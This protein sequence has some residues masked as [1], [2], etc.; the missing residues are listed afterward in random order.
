MTKSVP[1]GN[2][3][4]GNMASLHCRSVARIEN[5]TLTAI[6]DIDTDRLS[7]MKSRYQVAA[8]S[9]S[10]TLIKSGT[11]DAVLIATPHYDH[12]SI[13]I[14]A[15]KNG[16]HVMVEKPISVHKADCPCALTK[17]PKVSDDGG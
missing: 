14:A 3:G 6:C 9:D 10:M 16:L 8:F 2:I 17:T 4:L 7:K 11:C 15:L 13:G 5:I 12:T 1:L